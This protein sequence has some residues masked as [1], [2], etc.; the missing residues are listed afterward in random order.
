MKALLIIDV[1]NDFIPGGTL[2]VKEGDQV[3]P[4]IN[5]LQQK[6]DFIVKQN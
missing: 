3:V 2:A 4:I 5:E 1:Q 6:F